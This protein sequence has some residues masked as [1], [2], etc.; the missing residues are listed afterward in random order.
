MPEASKLILLDRDGVIN[1]DHGYVHRIEDWEW[2]PG[3]PE[4]IRELQLDGYDVV[5]V[6]NQSGVGR[7][8]FTECA[9]YELMATVVEDYFWHFGVNVPGNISFP[10]FHAVCWHH[11]ADG[12]GCRKPK[13]G[14]WYDNLQPLWDDVITH[15]SWFVDD[16]FENL[17]F[18]RELGFNL[19]WVTQVEDNVREPLD[20]EPFTS[21]HHFAET[22]LQR[23]I[24]WK[25]PQKITKT[26]D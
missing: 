5:I 6:T 25:S 22:L 13:T 8:M 1:V 16:N 24:P 19:A 26:R 11:P 18:G 17:G 20:Y 14:L 9:F 3:A 15:Q 21:L 2:C 4:A 10:R 12:C 23:S 7:G